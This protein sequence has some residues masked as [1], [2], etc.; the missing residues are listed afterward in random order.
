MDAAAYGNGESLD[1]RVSVAAMMTAYKFEELGL[2]KRQSSLSLSIDSYH[3]HFGYLS[4]LCSLHEVATQ[5]LPK[6]PLIH[7]LYLTKTW[8]S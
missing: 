5:A 6:R 3:D 8:N 4:H 1:E 7:G 2:E